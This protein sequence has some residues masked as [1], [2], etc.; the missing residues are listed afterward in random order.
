[1]QFETLAVTLADHIATVRLNRPDKLNAMNAAMWQDIRAALRWF[2]HIGVESALKKFPPHAD[3]RCRMTL[4]MRE[5][6]RERKLTQSALKSKTPMQAMKEWHQS[7]PHLFNK[8][9]YDRPGC[10]RY[11]LRARQTQSPFLSKGSPLNGCERRKCLGQPCIEILL[12]TMRFNFLAAY[13]STCKRRRGI[14]S[15]PK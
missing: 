9:P 14:C 10:D 1:M 6:A 12:G 13:S 4:V 8:R 5:R 11:Q 7:H 3:G 2:G 15:A